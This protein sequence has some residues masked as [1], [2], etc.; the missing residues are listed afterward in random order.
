MAGAA[1]VR[2]AQSLGH[3]HLQ[4]VHS[5]VVCLLIAR[6]APVK[7]VG[8]ETAHLAHARGQADTRTSTSQKQV[9]PSSLT[10]GGQQRA[11]EAERPARQSP[12]SRRSEGRGALGWVVE[13]RGWRG[14]QH[15]CPSW[16][17]VAGIQM[18][19][20]VGQKLIDKMSDNASC[21]TL[22]EEKVSLRGVRSP[23][24]N[25]AKSERAQ[26]QRRRHTL[27][28][29]LY[30]VYVHASE[31]TSGVHGSRWGIGKGLTGAL[32]WLLL[33]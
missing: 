20:N 30:H 21:A 17:W 18:N 31:R 3:R 11:S 8:G 13:R 28:E 9:L 29:E 14:G 10:S 33:R 4:L 15:W 5:L 12:M 32:S 27:L 23:Q 25:I 2:V 16:G 19:T 22:C 24:H 7:R 1:P 26:E 6:L